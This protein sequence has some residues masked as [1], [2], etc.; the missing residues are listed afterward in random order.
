MLTRILNK[1]GSLIEIFDTQAASALLGLEVSLST[2]SYVFC[3]I[4]SCIN[5]I[6]NEKRHYSKTCG[7]DTTIINDVNNSGSNS[8]RIF[9]CE[10]SLSTDLE[11]VENHMTLLRII[12]M[13]QIYLIHM[14]IFHLY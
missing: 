8:D 11:K 3:D 2:E 13:K 9:Q 7:K 6:K 14:E 4:Q 1:L 5:L 10:S 12:Q